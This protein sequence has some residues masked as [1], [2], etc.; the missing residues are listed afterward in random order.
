MSFLEVNNL[1]VEFDTADGIV[2]AVNNVSFSLDEGKI[3]AIVGE[4]GSGKS[5]TVFAMNG[6]LDHNGRASGSVKFEGKE[7]LNLPSREL[8][9]IRAQKNY[10]DFSR[11]N[12]Q[13]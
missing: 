1:K 8:N 6:L 10:N 9:L 13:S 12:D 3:L 11:S 7:I 5:Q 2:S 4:S